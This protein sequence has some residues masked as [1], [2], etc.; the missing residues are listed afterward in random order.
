MASKK[1]TF[2]LPEEIAAQLI[3]RLPAEER[4]RYVAEALVEK[5]AERERQLIKACEMANQDPRS[6]LR[7]TG[8]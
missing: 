4:S 5:L 8:V 3:R 2:T 7:R 6:S 1:M